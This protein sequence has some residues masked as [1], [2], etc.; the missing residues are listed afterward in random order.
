MTAH[1]P[2]AVRL[3]LATAFVPVYYWW[4]KRLLFTGA[5]RWAHR[6][7][8]DRR[9]DRSEIGGVMELSAAAVS[10]VLAVAVL[11]WL[12]GLPLSAIH[13]DS[14]DP[15]LLVLGVLVGIG[16]MGI[17]SF[18][19]RLVIEASLHRPGRPGRPGRRGS[20]LPAAASAGTARLGGPRDVGGWIAMSRGGWL[21][22]HFKTVEVLP[23]PLAVTVMAVQVGCEETVFRG[24]LFGY[25]G[26]AGLP[27]T[28]AVSVVLFVLMQCFFMG[29]WRAAMF[30][31]VG[32]LVMGIAHGLLFWAVPALPPLI[33][34]HVTFFLFAV[35]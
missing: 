11:L 34:A 1:W 9:Y 28:L 22:H 18:L 32:A 16:E 33:V 26:S 24:V 12:T 25:L 2:W 35:L 13:L 14:L 7:T 3:A 27:A 5:R 4:C 30:P 20:R 17:A 21:R 29:S 31:M 10:H 23:L 6:F 15:V 19:C 8:K